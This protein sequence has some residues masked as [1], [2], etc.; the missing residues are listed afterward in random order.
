MVLKGPHAAPCT[1]LK[2]GSVP[3]PGVSVVES[4]RSAVLVDHAVEDSASSYRGV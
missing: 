2:L 3:W 1:V 4:G